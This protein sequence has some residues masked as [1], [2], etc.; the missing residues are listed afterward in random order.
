MFKNKVWNDVKNDLS[1]E[2]LEHP[3]YNSFI[4]KDIFEI[5]FK[6]LLDL[7]DGTTMTDYIDFFYEKDTVLTTSLRFVGENEKLDF[8][9]LAVELKCLPH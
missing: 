2:L 5:E 7:L 4:P 1:I 6:S 8:Y 9:E 3:I